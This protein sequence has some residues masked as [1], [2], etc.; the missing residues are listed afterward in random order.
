MQA[1]GNDVIDAVAI[2]ITAADGGQVSGAVGHLQRLELLAT[3]VTAW[4]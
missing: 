4:S 3:F 2:K 1:A